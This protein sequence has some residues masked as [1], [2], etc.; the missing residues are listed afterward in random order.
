M[1]P[2]VFILL[3]ATIKC[4]ESN[5]LQLCQVRLDWL[6]SGSCC[7]AAREENFRSTCRY[8]WTSWISDWMILFEL[9]WNLISIFLEFYRSF[10]ALSCSTY[11]NRRVPVSQ[12]HPLSSNSWLITVQSSFLCNTTIRTFS[13]TIATLNSARLLNYCRPAGSC[14]RSLCSLSYCHGSDYRVR[15]LTSSA[16]RSQTGC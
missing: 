11:P 4:R 15:L 9:R 1:L 2:A 6:L 14:I 7:C 13:G 16:P 10:D 8:C 12:S 3:A 5:R